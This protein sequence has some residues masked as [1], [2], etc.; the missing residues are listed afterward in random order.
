MYIYFSCDSSLKM[1][2]S[3]I[4]ECYKFLVMLFWSSKYL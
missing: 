3:F 2:N 1:G 4:K